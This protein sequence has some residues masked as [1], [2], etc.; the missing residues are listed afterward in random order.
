M[1]EDLKNV[2]SD[3]IKNYVDYLVN[4]GD[5]Y[6]AYKYVAF[7]TFQQN[8][9][10]DAIDFYQMF[11]NSFSKAA[12]LV[13]QNSMGFINLLAQSFPNDVRN[14]FRDLYDES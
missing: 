13:Y 5:P 10:I 7:N 1:V 3:L 8:W 11:R 2:T 14:M 6:E 9:D 12:N 4:N